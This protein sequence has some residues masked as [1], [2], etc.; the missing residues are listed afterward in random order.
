MAE[1]TGSKKYL[2]GVDV[3]NCG[4]KLEKVVNIEYFISIIASLKTKPVQM[5][6]LVELVCQR[7]E[8]KI[9]RVRRTRVL[10]THSEK[11]CIR[12]EFARIA[13]DFR[14]DNRGTHMHLNAIDFYWS[15]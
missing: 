2:G 1:E 6:L 4:S 13:R 5:Y 11:G 9:Y 12:F 10:T 15:I 7:R 8:M 14:C 3:R